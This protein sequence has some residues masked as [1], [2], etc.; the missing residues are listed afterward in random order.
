[1]TGIVKLIWKTATETNNQGFSIERKIN[2]SGSNIASHWQELG[3]VNGYGSVSNS[4]SYSF[5]DK[6]LPGNGKYFYRL[7]QIDYNGSV[8]YSYEIQVEIN[9]KISFSL[10]QNYPNPFNPVTIINW[11]IPEDGKVTLKIF[12]AIGNE[13]AVLADAVFQAGMHSTPVNISKELSSGIYYYKLTAGSFTATKKM[14][15]LR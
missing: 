5:I 13:V 7:K 2:S 3:F 1:M 11:S 8:N 6:T 12:D 10:E 14:I 4:H 15:L 9:N